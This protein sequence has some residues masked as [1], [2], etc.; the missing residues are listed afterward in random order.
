MPFFPRFVTFSASFNTND[1]LIEYGKE[2]LSTQ[3]KILN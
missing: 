3:I 2:K 1:S